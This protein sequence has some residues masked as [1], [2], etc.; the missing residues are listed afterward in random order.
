MEHFGVVTS[1]DINYEGR[2]F[3]DAVLGSWRSRRDALLAREWM[4]D[5][6]FWAETGA[7]WEAAE[8]RREGQAMTVFERWGG[9][10]ES[11]GRTWFFGGGE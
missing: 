5:E 6:A 10:R 7:R 11:N 4:M 9:E 2:T 3:L 1:V 8:R